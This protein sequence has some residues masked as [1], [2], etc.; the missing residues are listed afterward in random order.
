MYFPNANIY[1]VDTNQRVL[2]LA[3]QNNTHESITFSNTIDTVPMVDIVFAM[4]VFCRW[5]DTHQLEYNDIYKFDVFENEVAILDA[6]LKNVGV[7]VVY[8]SNYY[9]SDTQT[10]KKYAGMDAFFREEEVR[11][12]NRDGYYSS[13]RGPNVFYKAGA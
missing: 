9:F 12:F 2:D 13:F 5:P 11:K 1:G 4:S 6:K 7:F 10:A 3:K 8:N